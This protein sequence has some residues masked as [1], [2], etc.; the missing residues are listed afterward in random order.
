MPES[1]ADKEANPLTRSALLAREYNKI[2][3]E[4]FGFYGIA[5][6]LDEL[7]IQSQ[8]L[9]ALNPFGEVFLQR[10][11]GCFVQA[12]ATQG[13]SRARAILGISKAHRAALDSGTV[14]QLSPEQRLF[15]SPCGEKSA[16]AYL[17]F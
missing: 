9:L 3:D 6:I 17:G 12:Y 15:Y 11:R 1:C 14:V 13:S 2:S 7:F 5:H 4:E 10:L 8:R 16:F